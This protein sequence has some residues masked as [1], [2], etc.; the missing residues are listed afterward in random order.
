MQN[1]PSNEL[2][3]LYFCYC[4]CCC[5]LDLI[6]RSTYWSR[7]GFQQEDRKKARARK[8]DRKKE[9]ESTIFVP[10]SATSVFERLPTIPG[11]EIFNNPTTTKKKHGKYST[12]CESRCRKNRAWNALIRTTLDSSLVTLIGNV[13]IK[14]IFLNRFCVIERSSI[15]FKGFS[16][17]SLCMPKLH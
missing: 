2:Y 16:L 11:L 17:I 4:C 15:A 14:N 9:W 5:R 1:P 10:A 13:I 8:K 12:W 7:D 6:S 3:H